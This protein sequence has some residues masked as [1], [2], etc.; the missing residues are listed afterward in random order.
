MLSF[1]NLYGDAVGETGLARD[2]NRVTVGYAREQFVGVVEA[3]AEFDA[4]IRHFPFGI[5]IDIFVARSALF[6]DGAV[7]NNDAAALA[8]VHADAGKHAGLDGAVAVIDSDFGRECASGGVDRRIDAGDAA[9][10]F[11]ALESIESDVDGHASAYERQVAL[12]DVDDDLDG[13]RELTDG[14]HGLIACHVARVIVAGGDDAVD[15]RYELSVLEQIVIL[16]AGGVELSLELVDGLL[17]AGA[18]LEELH[19]AVILALDLVE[20]DFRLGDVGSVHDDESLAASDRVADFD[21]NRF[22][23]VGCRRRYV[24]DVFGLDIG[25]VFFN[26]RHAF[27]SYSADLDLRQLVFDFCDGAFVVIAAGGHNHCERHD[28]IRFHLHHGILY[29]NILIVFCQFVVVNRG[30]AE[31]KLEFAVGDKI[32]V[33]RLVVSETG[34][35]QGEL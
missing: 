31:Q 32:V 12:A 16:T 1:D 4:V 15:R 18:N 7:G 19:G 35:R 13:R 2:D 9:G 27:D 17:G 21:G 11:A 26:L 20:I 23:A 8:E 24:V 3:A 29:F 10:K 34:P 28:I 22:D 30:V 25:S 14:E 6:D 5:D 33:Y